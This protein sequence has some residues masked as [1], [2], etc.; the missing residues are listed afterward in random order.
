MVPDPIYQHT[1]PEV[2]AAH[3]Q[4]NRSHI[5]C[6]SF[7]Y[8]SD[9]TIPDT[10]FKVKPF[11]VLTEID[12]KPKLSTLT[13]MIISGLSEFIWL[14][15]C[16]KNIQKFRKSHHNKRTKVMTW[17]NKLSGV[18]YIFCNKFISFSRLKVSTQLESS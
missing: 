6:S 12:F 7:V 9:K 8:M 18:S 3:L 4:E 5:N 10:L 17:Y 1:F 14:K 15:D 11:L 13:A 16:I 2:F